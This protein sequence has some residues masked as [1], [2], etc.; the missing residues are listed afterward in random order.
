VA[1]QKLHFSTFT[2]VWSRNK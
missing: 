2:T 1:S